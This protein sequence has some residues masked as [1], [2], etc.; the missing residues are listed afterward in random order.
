MLVTTKKGRTFVHNLETKESLWTAPPELQEIINVMPPVDREQEKRE[1][2]ERRRRRAE[3]RAEEERMK[4]VEKRAQAVAA[5]IVEPVAK[6]ARVEDSG[7]QVTPAAPGT[8]KTPQ[9]TQPVA[10]PDEEME[11][12]EEY[13]SEE[14]DEK[15]S[16]PQEFTEEDIAWQLEQM[17][18]QYGL[19]DEDFEEG[20]EL[21]PE[22]SIAIFREMLDEYAISPYSTWNDALPKFVDDQRYTVIN[23]TKARKDVFMAWCKDRSH[24][25]R[26]EKEKA[27][28]V[29][30]RI[31]FWAFL[32]EHSSA[33]LFWAEFKR[34][35]RKEP[36]MKD[37]KLS[38]KEREKMYRDFVARMSLFSVTGTPTDVH[39]HQG[40]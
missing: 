39:R 21:A 3:R 13:E 28:K 7:E 16:G 17:A 19:V 25:L 26:L 31:P 27:K 18:E 8:V 23:T 32:K 35:W 4:A 5:G 15:P 10:A 38:D 20:D 36:L 14:E 1:R 12:E 37:T 30:P 29:D 6:K 11:E 9:P 24:Q 33:K 34:K 2:V 22:E 40:I